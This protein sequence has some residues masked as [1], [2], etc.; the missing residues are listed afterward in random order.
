MSDVTIRDLRK[1]GG[2]VIDR[3]DSRGML[4]TTTVILLDRISG[5]SALR[6][7]AARVYGASIDGLTVRCHTPTPSTRPDRRDAPQC[8]RS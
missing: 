4:D 1:H 3:V 2:E 6:E 7:P 5:A 8:R